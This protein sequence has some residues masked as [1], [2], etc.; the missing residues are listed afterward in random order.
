M[1]EYQLINGLQTEGKERVKKELRN[2]GLKR[3]RMG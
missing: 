2:E 1:V 3:G